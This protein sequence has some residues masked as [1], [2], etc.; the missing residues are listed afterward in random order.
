MLHFNEINRIVNYYMDN[1]N[2]LIKNKIKYLEDF[3]TQE[4][5][6]KDYVEVLNE[7]EKKQHKINLKE[8]NG[9]KDRT[10]EILKDFNPKDIDFNI[11]R[12][13]DTIVFFEQIEID[14]I[15]VSE[16][17]VSLKR[18]WTSFLKRNTEF[19]E[20]VFNVYV[21]N[22]FLALK[23]TIE[24]VTPQE[25]GLLNADIENE[26]QDI[27]KI[28]ILIEKLKEYKNMNIFIGK[29]NKEIEKNLS[30]LVDSMNDIA[31][32][33]FIEKA[34]ECL[35]LIDSEKQNV[36]YGKKRVPV[37]KF[38]NK[39]DSSIYKYTVKFGD[40][41]VKYESFFDS[42]NLTIEDTE[43][44]IY[45]EDYPL[46]GIFAGKE[47]VEKLMI[48]NDYLNAV[49]VLNKKSQMIFLLLGLFILTTSTI[50]AFLSEFVIILNLI[51]SLLILVSFNPIMKNLKKNISQRFKLSDIFVFTKLN[52]FVVTEGDDLNIK[53]IL[54]GIIQNFDNTILN[55]EELKKHG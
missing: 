6:L 12:L 9:L 14:L 49:E 10:I 44:Y 36:V 37:Y 26:K 16:S 25:I 31:V 17:L 4:I 3:R 5:K 38:I 11:K 23:R 27:E 28:I 20:S 43:Q 21:E 54:I 35:E 24:G 48:D 53:K 15:E 39:G 29:E 13:Q 19:A 22:K 55:E 7:L 33:D 41:F 46:K 40:Y 42:T 47:V 50:T 18:I 32:P 2:D 45:L 8:F 52:Y 30:L 34:K 1:N 51:I